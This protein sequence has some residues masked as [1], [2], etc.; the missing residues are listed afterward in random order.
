MLSV[1]DAAQLYDQLVTPMQTLERWS[2][3]RHRPVGDADLRATVWKL[4]AAFE[5]LKATLALDLK[6]TVREAREDDLSPEG[7]VEDF[8]SL[9]TLLD[10][11][12]RTRTLLTGARGDR[13]RRAVRNREPAAAPMYE[14]AL[15]SVLSAL[16]EIEK[17]LVLYGAGTEDDAPLASDVIPP[18]REDLPVGQS[19]TFEF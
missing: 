18:A 4:I 2:V 6:V 5:E 12:R 11:L 9:D 13:F 1:M 8:S 15:A 16:Q 17:I 3:K 7:P 19:V 14:D 10:S